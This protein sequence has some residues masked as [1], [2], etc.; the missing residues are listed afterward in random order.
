MNKKYDNN[1]I[2]IASRAYFLQ[3]VLLGECFWEGTG[4]PSELV[5]IVIG[6]DE[7]EG[8]AMVVE[9]EKADYDT[10]WSLREGDILWSRVVMY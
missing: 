8:A 9:M 2:I 7:E 10:M 4:K 3:I 5:V 6:A 1:N